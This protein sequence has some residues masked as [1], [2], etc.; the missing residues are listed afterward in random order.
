MKNLILRLWNGDFGLPRT[1]WEFAIGYG[2]LLNITTTALTFAVLAM[3]G[4]AWLALAIY[5]CN[6]PYTV[7]IALA[8][9][10]TAGTYT[11]PEHWVGAARMT[12]LIW[13]VVM[14]VV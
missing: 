13:A 8:V 3:N 7:F 5:L 1:F 6:A 9:W 2:T 11:G 14:L 4:P 12:I 10:R